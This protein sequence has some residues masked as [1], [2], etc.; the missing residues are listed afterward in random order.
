MV[1][2]TSMALDNVNWDISLDGDGNF[3][4]VTDA[5]AVAQN[6]A[7]LLRTFQGE[8]YYDT[9]RGI[10]YFTQILGRDYAPSVIMGLYNKAAK[11]VPYV[12]TART[13][14]TGISNRLVT[15][16]VEVTNSIDSTTSTVTL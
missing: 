2:T 11:T 15:G 7:T 14:I 8:C 12:T 6:V 1:T 16:K 4:L 13:T 9:D 3:A 10:P 5:E